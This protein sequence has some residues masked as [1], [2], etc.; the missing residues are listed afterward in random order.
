[1]SKK[2]EKISRENNR[3]LRFFQKKKGFLN[4][5]RNFFAVVGFTLFL[6]II[7]EEVLSFST[8]RHE[9]DLAEEAV[10]IEG[11]RH[12]P[13]LDYTAP[14]RETKNYCANNDEVI[15]IYAYGGSTM[16]GMPFE[17]NKSIP[18]YLSE[19]LCEKGLDVNVFNYGMLGYN[20]LQE[21]VKLF[22]QLKSGKEPDVVIFYD[23]VNDVLSKHPTLPSNKVTRDVFE[24]YTY[25]QRPFSLIRG[26]LSN[27]YGDLN[28]VET[29]FFDYSHLYFDSGEERYTK[30]AE[31]YIN[32]VE[33][34]KA[35]EDHYNFKS[36][37]YW[38]P[39][40][41]TKKNLS[42]EEKELLEN[43]SI[44][45]QVEEYNEG[46]YFFNKAF[47]ENGYYVNNIADIFDD[48]SDTI[49]VDDCHKMPSGNKIVAERMAEDIIDYL[50]N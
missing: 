4:I 10:H 2:K 39:S 21:T 40:L 33:I 29:N 44:K 9:G 30:L 17:Y 1:M 11:V 32:S 24:Y 37:F 50:N 14:Y 38:Q 7:I 47:L 36:F 42:E 45:R 22:L 6:L 15:T 5:L 49:F 25:H 13:F 16:W 43:E 26:V 20:S 41:G 35:L 19:I 31:R 23:G 27:L 3:F 28:R 34:I 18:S 48:Y 12:H 46:Y 8:Q